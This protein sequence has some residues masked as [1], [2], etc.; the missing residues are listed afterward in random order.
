MKRSEA[1]AKARRFLTYKRIEDAALEGEILLRQVLGISRTQLYAELDNDISQSDIEKLLE[2]VSRRIKGEPSAYISG[3]KQFYGL[4]F[5]V[6]QDVLIPRPETELLVEQA[7]KLCRDYHYSII[8]DIGTGC[9]NIAISLAVNIPEVKIYATDISTNALAVAEQ[10]CEKH[11]VKDRITFLQGNLL[12]PL[13]E[14]V[15]VLIAN[16][17]YVRKAD[18]PREGPLSFE[19]RL[20]LD[21]GKSGTDKMW[22]FCWRASGKLKKEGCLLLEIGQGQ[23]AAVRIALMDNFLEGSIEI[24]KDLSGID[25]V[26]KLRL[27]SL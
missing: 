13:P 22:D 8:A 5:I 19:P 18:I 26:I 1:L 14:R 23:T 15:D 12:E 9:G 20:A 7:I 2:L 16:L 27:T 24:I 6:N 11:S 3:M 21:G 25:R 10:N 4:D 17:P